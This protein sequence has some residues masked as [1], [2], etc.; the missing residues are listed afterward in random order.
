MKV[1]GRML[2]WLEHLAAALFVLV[3]VAGVGVYFSKML[4]RENAP[5]V[6][7]LMRGEKRAISQ[8]DYKRWQNMEAEARTRTKVEAEEQTGSGQANA[9]FKKERSHWAHEFEKERAVLSVLDGMLKDRQKT[10]GE[11]LAVLNRDKTAFADQKKASQDA[12][13]QARMKRLQKLVQGME[14]ELIAEDFLVK[15]S[16]GSST[17]KSEVVDMLHRMPARLSAEI[18][19]AIADSSLRVEIMK[20]MRKP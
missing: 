8:E 18:I 14:P 7:A 4:T 9:G 5:E 12:A 13:Q 10:F 19:S 11:Q 15:W 16:K 17:D 6:W 20:E 3:L 2:S 1:L